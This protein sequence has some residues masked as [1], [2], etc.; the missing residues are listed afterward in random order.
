MKELE[1][2]SEIQSAVLGTATPMP[3]DAFTTGY[4]SSQMGARVGE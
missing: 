2:L 1:P 3:R 4:T